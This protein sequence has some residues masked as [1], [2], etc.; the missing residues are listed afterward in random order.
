MNKFVSKYGQ[1]LL[2]LI[3]PYGEGE[4]VNYEAYTELIHYLIEKD[5]CDSLIFQQMQISA[6][7][8]LRYC[9]LFCQIT[10]KHFFLFMQ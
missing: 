9:K 7:R 8:H 1:I 10:H 3:T 6:D 2:P 5:L 4:E